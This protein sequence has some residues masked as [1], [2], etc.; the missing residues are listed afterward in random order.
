MAGPDSV[1]ID[2]NSQQTKKNAHGAEQE[3]NKHTTWK[4]TEQWAAWQWWWIEMTWRWF[5][6]NVFIL[7][8]DTA[9]GSNTVD[10]NNFNKD[11]FI[12]KWK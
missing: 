8:G 9:R 7:S 11:F 1:F 5:H 12:K 6:E 10:K 2:G 3:K 4:S